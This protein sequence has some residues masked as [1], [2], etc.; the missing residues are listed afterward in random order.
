MCIICITYL[1]IKRLGDLDLAPSRVGF[2]GVIE[3]IALPC[4]FHISIYKMKELGRILDATWLPAD[5]LS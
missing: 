5:A 1:Y 4:S 2:V 3:P